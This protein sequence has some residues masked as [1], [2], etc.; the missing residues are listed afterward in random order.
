MRYGQGLIKAGRI[1]KVQH[2]SCE[3]LPVDSTVMRESIR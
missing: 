2:R 3:Y 1:R